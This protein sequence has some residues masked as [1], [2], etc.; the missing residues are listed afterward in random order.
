MWLNQTKQFKIET[1]QIKDFM[2]FPDDIEYKKLTQCTT[3]RVFLV[4]FKTSNKKLFYWMQ[5]SPR[6]VCMQRDSVNIE[7]SVS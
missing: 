4:R 1:N 2:I 3:G 6:K 7:Y 5:V